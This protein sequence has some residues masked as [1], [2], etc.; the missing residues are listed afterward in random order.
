[1]ILLNSYYHYLFQ[2]LNR[3]KTVSLT[4]MFT[5]GEKVVDHNSWN[6]WK[7]GWKYWRNKSMNLNHLV[8]Q[9]LLN[10][11]MFKDLTIYLI[12]HSVTGEG[13]VCLTRFLS[14]CRKI[15]LTCDNISQ[16]KYLNRKENYVSFDFIYCRI[17][18][19]LLNTLHFESHF[20]NTKISAKG[21]LHMQKRVTKIKPLIIAWIQ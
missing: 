14:R 15:W 1:M 16:G 8:M 4:C 9:I 2:G 3:S 10:C 5:S 13:N 20:A 18:G 12:S 17:F 11:G 19:K 21:T 7:M 6:G